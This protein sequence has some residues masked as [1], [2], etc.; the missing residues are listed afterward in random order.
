MLS[1]DSFITC[2]KCCAINNCSTTTALKDLK[3]L[4]KEGI[5]LESEIGKTFIYSINPDYKNIDDIENDYDDFLT[6]N[7]IVSEDYTPFIVSDLETENSDTAP[8]KANKQPVAKSKISADDVNTS[9]EKDITLSQNITDDNEDGKSSAYDFKKLK[10]I[11]QE[12][13]KESKSIV[14]EDDEAV[15]MFYELIGGKFD[16][17][18]SNYSD[19]NETTNKDESSVLISASEKV[20]QKLA[21]DMGINDIY[22]ARV[23]KKLNPKVF[24]MFMLEREK[25]KREKDLGPEK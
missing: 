5:I 7:S 10:K 8:Q 14:K 2:R 1:E 24:P 6:K 18:I 19:F 16:K 13:R 9:A 17:N 15:K 25:M 4:T 21:S 20:M 3:V 12:Y 11:L 23:I 22:D